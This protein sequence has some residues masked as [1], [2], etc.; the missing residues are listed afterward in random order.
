M[1]ILYLAN[2][3]NIGGIT[4]Y[5]L[6]LACGMK[7]KGHNVYIA[8]SGG[9]LKD[10]FTDEG[11]NFIPIPIKTKKEISPKILAS[12]FKLKK[13]DKNFDFDIVH[14]NSRT[15][16]VLANLLC[17]KC[18]IAHVSTAHGFFKKRILRKIFPGWGMKVIA[19]SAQVRDHLVCDFKVSDGN[20]TVI[21]NGIDVDRYRVQGTNYREKKKEEL[22]LSK[23]P[24]VGI[25]ARLSDV[26]GHIYLLKAMKLV[27]E[28]FPHSQLLIVGEGRM[29]TTL[30]NLA[31]GLK[32]SNSVFFK[33]S[34]AKTEEIL[35]VI[36]VFVL[37]SLREGLGLALIEA[38]AMGLGVIGSKAGGIPALVT[39]EL[40]GLLVEAKDPDQL[41]KSIIRLLEDEKLRSQL[42]ANARA[43]ISSNFSCAEM[44][45]KTEQVYLECA[46]LK[47]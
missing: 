45:N 42:G 44:I 40:N 8:S 33:P 23:G 6:T 3:L 27:L 47:H 11:I 41:A 34:V 22:G 13:A 24:V 46:K 43:F 2:H 18:S 39:P 14:S 10:A 20:I 29:R 12:M 16:Q 1:N 30:V 37:P 17:K 36:D 32:I 31:K 19:V 28:K 26:K 9:Q 15:T 4:S 21:H 35:P 38:M 5:C 7:K 25:I